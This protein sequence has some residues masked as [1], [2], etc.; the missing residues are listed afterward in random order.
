MK[1]II[2]LVFTVFWLSDAI[3][4]RNYVRNLTIVPDEEQVIFTFDIVS[5]APEQV[6]NICLKSY[7][8][9]ISPLDT[10]GSIGQLQKPGL[11]L[12]I[13]WNYVEDGYS[14][15]QIDVQRLD[16]VA[17]NALA[18][19]PAPPEIGIYAGLAGVGAGLSAGYIG[20]DRFFK[21][22]GDYEDYKNYAYPED[23]SFEER[24]DYFNTLNTRYKNAQYF[25]YGGAVVSAAS[26][27]VILKRRKV[28]SKRRAIRKSQLLKN[29]CDASPFF[30]KSRFIVTENG[31]GIAFAF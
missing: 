24:D 20:A 8:K 2:L 6:F 29:Q 9:K 14:L 19:E 4:Q 11:N 1:K 21:V 12:K 30:E 13:Y 25:M 17:I 23:I 10:K 28:L 15:N 27:W 7:L 5:D 18:L 16:V 31:A 22:R 3:S 26:I